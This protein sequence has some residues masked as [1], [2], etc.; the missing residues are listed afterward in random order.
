M[1]LPTLIRNLMLRDVPAAA[2]MSVPSGGGYAVAASAA[3]YQ[4]Y[5]RDGYQ[6]NEIVFSAIELRATSAAEPPVIGRRKVGEARRRQVRAWLVDNGVSAMQADYH[7]KN[8]HEDVTEHPLIDLLRKPNPFMEAYEF[9]S[10]VVMH[11]DLAGNAYALKG[12]AANGDVVGLWLL[13]PDRVRVV[14]ESPHLISA[15]RYTL[16]GQSVL[17]PPEDIIHFR[18]RHPLEDHYGQPPMMAITGRVNVDNYM[19]DFVAAFFRNGGQPGAVLAIKNKLSQEAKD[20]LREQMRNAYAGPAGWFDWLVLDANEASYTPLQMQ[21]GQRG[22]VV[23][24]LN[25]ISESRISMAFGIPGSILGL[26]IGYESSSYANQRQAWENFWDITMSPLF[27]ELIA[28]LTRSLL[29]EFGGLDE[30]LFDLSQVR[31]LQEDVDKLHDR[32]RRDV[33]AGLAPIEEA[34][35]ALGMEPSPSEGTFLI[36]ANYIPTPAKE[37]GNAPAPAEQAA[38]ALWA[39]ASPPPAAL[40]EARIIAEARCPDCGKLTGRDVPEGNKEWCRRCKKEYPAGAEADPP[41][42]VR[43]RVTFSDGRTAEVVEER[44]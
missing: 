43:R 37:L 22:L 28:P 32:W 7:V 5:A 8:L 35:A 40:P 19:R 25:A 2:A 30:L 10:T 1:G 26:L 31:A 27:I 29:P 17:I 12:R 38:R 9:W 21:L 13:R 33:A 6:R 15:Y 41:M 3:N 11:R 14:P 39:L 44:V 18:T 42:A 36:P 16:G 24:E 34:R 4:A 20:D 23:P